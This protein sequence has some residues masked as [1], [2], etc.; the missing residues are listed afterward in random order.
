MVTFKRQAP[1]TQKAGLP[2]AVAQNMNSP[3]L[4]AE[5]NGEFQKGFQVGDWV[6][7]R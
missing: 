7:F 6:S 2:A 4:S 3:P 1:F 5:D